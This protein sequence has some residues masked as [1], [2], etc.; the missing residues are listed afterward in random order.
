MLHS[1]SRGIGNVIGR[2]FIS[3]ARKEMMRHKVNLPDRDLSYFSEGSELFDDYVE[4]VDWAQDYAMPAPFT[5]PTKRS[6][7]CCTPTW[8]RKAS[9]VNSACGA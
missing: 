7:S 9:P 6:A 4:A 3:A 2:Y 5:P 1:G 8:S